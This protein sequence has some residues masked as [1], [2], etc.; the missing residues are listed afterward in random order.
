MREIPT[1]LFELMML[2]ADSG[3]TKTDWIYISK[4]KSITQFETI[5]L[6]PYIVDQQ[7]VSAAIQSLSISKDDVCHLFFY[8]AGCDGK[9]KS[10]W[11]R[12]ILASFFVNS[13][14]NIYSDLLASAHALLGSK[15]GVVGILGTGSNVAFFDGTKLIP[16]GTSL[17]YLLGDEGSGNA[18]G[19]KFLKYYLTDKLDKEIV[20]AID[21]DKELILSKLY[22]HPFPNRY[23]ASFSKLMLKHRQHLQMQEIITQTFDEF[24]TNCLLPFSINAI[25][26]TGSIAHHFSTELHYCCQ[27]H[28]ITVDAILEKPISELSR[29]HL[30]NQ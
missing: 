25:S 20:K 6:N 10:R 30:K 2:I 17:G 26:I 12:D 13:T 14:I 19:K 23:L 21:L 5:G 4:D 7:T 24:I 11:L 8:G 22:S 1:T 9:E 27:K 28:D 18:M 15:S 3:S 29:F 16:F